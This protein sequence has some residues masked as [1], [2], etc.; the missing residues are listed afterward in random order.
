MS[1]EKA[2]Q[3]L[4]VFTF[5]DGNSDEVTDIL[6]KTV[7]VQSFDGKRTLWESPNTDSIEDSTIKAFAT[8]LKRNM[9]SKLLKPDLDKREWDK[10][11]PKN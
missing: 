9:L 4:T 11:R 6:P 7:M 2:S 3:H 1:K 5:D 8:E 10:T